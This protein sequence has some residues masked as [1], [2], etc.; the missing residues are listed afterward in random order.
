[1]TKLSEN[2][3]AR[4]KDDGRFKGAIYRPLNTNP[5]NWKILSEKKILSSFNSATCMTLCA[6]CGDAL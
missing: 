2:T 6:G 4:L 1:M 5:E 3:L